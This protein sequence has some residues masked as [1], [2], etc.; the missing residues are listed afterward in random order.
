MKRVRYKRWILWLLIIGLAVPLAVRGINH[1]WAHVPWYQADRSATDL[2]PDPATTRDAVVQVYGAPTYGWRGIFAM[3][4]WIVL[5]PRNAARYVRWEVVGWGGGQ[6]V[7]RDRGGPD[8][9]WYGK[10]PALLVDHRGA[11]AEALIPEI[12]AAVA[13]YPHAG[14]Y[15]AYPGPNSNTFLA[16]IARSVPDLA[17]DLPPT[18]IGKD[19]RPLTEPVG[20][21]PSGRG[22]QVNVLGLGGLILSPEEGIE[23]N[24][25]GLGLGLDLL[26][27]ALRLPGFGRIGTGD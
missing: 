27:P 23:L 19:Y 21:P 1:S 9:R 13:S 3:H 17:L 12:E 6:V 10:L 16:H 15:R 7:R 26:D 25:L 24:V 18:A 11:E 22:V 8:D 4:T 20:A 2:A 14:R 5:K